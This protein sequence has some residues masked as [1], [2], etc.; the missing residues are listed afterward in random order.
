VGYFLLTG[1][2]VFDSG[3]VFEVIASHLQTA[4]MP[5]SKRLGAALPRDLEELVMACL[6]KDPALRPTSAAELS[7]RL[8]ATEARKRW[9]KE[10][11]EHA[12]QRCL[13]LRE[14]VE[15]ARA[16]PTRLTVAL[17]RRPA[18]PG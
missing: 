14:G 9:S 17:A 8:A 10:A 6:E 16:A 12:W 11:A 13:A 4:P 5:P 15:R 18:E 2:P 7:Q 3:S 1:K